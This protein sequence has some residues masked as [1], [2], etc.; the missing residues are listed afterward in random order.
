MPIRSITFRSF[1]ILCIAAASRGV[2]GEVA[3]NAGS[4]TYDSH[5]SMSLASDR[6][7]WIAWH[8]YENDREQIKVRKLAP[9][10]TPSAAATISAGPVHGPPAVVADVGESVWV[11]WSC[12]REARWRIVAREFRDRQWQAEV[13]VSEATSDCIHPSAVRVGNR[14]LA[15]S[16]SCLK[17]GRFVIESRSSAG[18]QW[19]A[20]QSISSTS[21]DAYRPTLAASGRGEVWAF[22]D[23]YENRN[24]TIKGRRILPVKGEIERVSP[25]GEYCLKPTALA[26]THGVYVAWLRKQ[27]AMGGPGVISQLHTLH[28][29]VRRDDRWKLIARNEPAA[30][31]TQG[32]VAKIAPRPV[33]T[34][35][36]LGRR[37]A[38][39][40]LDDGQHAWLLWERKTDHRGSTAYVTG[41][42]VACQMHSGDWDKP[43]VLQQGW[44]DYHLAHPAH[45]HERRFVMAASNVPT[46]HR[47]TYRRLQCD[48]DEA[49]EFEQEQWT[50]WR[51]IELPIREELTERREIRS[52]GKSYKLFWADLHCHSSL[53]ADAEGEPDEL[54]HYARDRAQIDVV[55][56]SDNDFYIVPMTQY[57]YELGNFFARVSS[58]RG[59]FLSLKGYEWT[60]RIPG[61]PRADVA[62][63]GNWTH[64]YRN[65][66]QPN[67]RTVIYPDSGGP[68]LRF[69]E[70]GN[71]I[72]RL[73]QAVE[74]AGGLTLTQHPQFEP[75]GHDVE[76]AMEVTAG[77]ARYIASHP[78]TFHE[79][80]NRGLRLGFVANGDSHR[81]AP[82]LSGALTGIYAQELS[83]P[84]ILDALRQRR[85]FATNGSRIFVDARIS[86]DQQA[87][88]K[89]MGQQITSRERRVTLSLHAIGTREIDSVVLVR[90]GEEI[91]TFK[92]NGTDQLQVKFTDIDLSPG[93][94]W[95]YWRIAQKRSAPPLPGNLMTAFG[96]LAWSSPLWLVVQ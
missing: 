63:Q 22:W 3:L 26:T 68:I 64:P 60:S 94:H 65:R 89:L 48:L 43:V 69:P 34:G 10:G 7:L 75:T 31:L 27:D 86:A 58:R 46:L 14:G 59:Q 30:E 80:L 70:V 95:Y 92:G 17:N 42:L 39:M 96:S 55:L 11:I 74:E 29:A 72:T 61:E 84:A 45:A 23:Q 53:S 91:R 52:G 82:G 67:H 51:A 20:I 88:A 73:N 77:W 66:S 12:R 90:N 85:C 9:D 71:D 40:L 4:T 54:T 44:V 78:Q 87:E 2:Q 62:D 35:G 49:H 6:S 32:L 83:T 41:D 1:S 5:P 13:S 37:T 93:T 47:R 81:R 76:V 79:P 50:G 33:A 24:Y 38:P 8:A 56:F 36:Y 28:A 16:W 19:S 18:E 57:E 21:G 25:H 15:V